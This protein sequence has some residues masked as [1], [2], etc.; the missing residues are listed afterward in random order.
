MVGHYGDELDKS[1]SG[2][3]TTKKVGTPLTERLDGAQCACDG[4]IP[5]DEGVHS[6]KGC[7]R[8]N[9]TEE[10]AAKIYDSML[11]TFTQRRSKEAGSSDST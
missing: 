9:L 8:N 2:I 4:E 7:Y 1:Y 6:I 5:N 3:Y 11:E 10:E